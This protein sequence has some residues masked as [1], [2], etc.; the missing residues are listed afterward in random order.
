MVDTQPTIGLYPKLKYMKLR[1]DVPDLLFRGDS[2][3]LDLVWSPVYPETKQGWIRNKD[4]FLMETGIAVE[5]PT[6]YFGLLTIR[7]GF[8]ADWGIAPA[9]GV[10]II[11]A[12]YRGEIK[13]L[14]KNTTYDD[15][16]LVRNHRYLQLVI[17]PYANTNSLGIT[18]VDALSETARGTG[19][20]GS[21]G[22]IEI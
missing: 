19:G 3:G 1:P 16:A 6:G 18:L 12:D 14:L 22:M 13:M 21:T 15:V 20:F 17:V 2:A 7:S 8:A 9:A 10:G 4:F 11:D 5:I